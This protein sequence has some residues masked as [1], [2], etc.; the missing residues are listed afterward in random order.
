MQ[1]IGIAALEADGGSAKAA[2]AHWVEWG[3]QN[4]SK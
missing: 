2:E 3:C 4:D 1:Q